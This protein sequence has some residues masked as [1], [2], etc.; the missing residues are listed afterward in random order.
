MD[1]TES[2]QRR[3]QALIPGQI[4]SA[5]AQPGASVTAESAALP[6]IGGVSSE[7]AQVG[8]ALQRKGFWFNVNAEVVIYGATEPDAKVTCF[9]REVR[10]RPD[11][12]FSFR[13][14]LPDG[15]YEF[16][17]AAVSATGDDRRSAHFRFGRRTEYA[18]EVGAH[19]QDPQ[20]SPPP[21]R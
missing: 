7:E 5:P 8:P 4:S 11:G 13:F 15:A 14:A 21:S 16:P 10:L 9:G 12:T 18:G 19:P 6:V 20:L 1:V 3:V 17:V 2:V